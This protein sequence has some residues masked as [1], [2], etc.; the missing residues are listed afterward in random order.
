MEGL[1]SQ[2]RQLCIANA[3]KVAAYMDEYA[4]VYRYQ[5]KYAF[6]LYG[7][8]RPLVSDEI[9]WTNHPRLKQQV[10]PQGIRLTTFLRSR[11]RR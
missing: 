6:Q 7:D 10:A 11:A 8:P 4:T 1:I 2:D 9:L 3:R 5:G